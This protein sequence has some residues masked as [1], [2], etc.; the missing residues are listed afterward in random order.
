[1][2]GFLSAVG[3]RARIE[4]TLLRLTWKLRSSA[5]PRRR[6]EIRRELR[7]HLLATTGEAGSEDA[8][9]RLGDLDALA[10]EYAEAERGRPLE[11]RYGAGL[12]AAIV[13]WVFVVFA[14]GRRL[15]DDRGL[16]LAQRGNFDPWSWT[17]GLPNGKLELFRLFGDVEHGL[18]FEV[19]MYRLGYVVF[20][21]LA[22]VLASRL[23]RAWRTPTV[24]RGRLSRS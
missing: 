22:F 17:A 14:D 11:P 8:V 3:A 1:M 19:E 7:A 23:W 18:L 9:A 13:A 24:L 4:G 2:T 12:I 20:P 10:E 16:D 15:T 5:S 6:R 21:L